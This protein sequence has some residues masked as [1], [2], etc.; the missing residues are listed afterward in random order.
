MAEGEAVHRP[1]LSGHPS[2]VCSLSPLP[3][4]S[5]KSRTQGEPQ[6]S[7]DG[8]DIHVAAMP[9]AWPGWGPMGNPHSRFTAFKVYSLEDKG[10]RRKVLAARRK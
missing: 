2:A 6:T 8:G 10:V 7:P 3:F 5:R 4:L 1:S 9:H